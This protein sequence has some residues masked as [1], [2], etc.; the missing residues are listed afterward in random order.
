MTAF[1]EPNEQNSFLVDHVNLLRHSFQHYLGRDLIDPSLSEVE[2][3]QAIYHAPF[4]VVSHNTASD[5]IFNYGNQAAQTR[6]EMTWEELTALPSRKSAELPDR[7]ERARLLAT[8]STQ[9]F[10]ENYAGIRIS[11]GGK[12]FRIAQA[13][14]WNL[15]DRQNQYAG[16]AAT[17][18]HW[19]DL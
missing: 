9:G 1:P 6:F 12:R 11:K 8:V 14:V 5:P 18:S 13:T 17:F 2:A 3:A 15:I 10:I 4:V 7:E 16:Q 19:I